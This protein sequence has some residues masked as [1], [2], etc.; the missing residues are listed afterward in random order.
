M[1]S[2]HDLTVWEGGHVPCTTRDCEHALCSCSAHATVGDVQ[3]V[4]F[5]FRSK[6]LY[7]QYV[8]VVNA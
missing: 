8:L 5:S 2:V 3:K 4:T 7:A 1:Y 6:S